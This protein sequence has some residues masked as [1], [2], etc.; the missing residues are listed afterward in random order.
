MKNFNY[1][2]VMHEKQKFTF[3]SYCKRCATGR[4]DQIMSPKQCHRENNGKSDDKRSAIVGPN[5]AEQHEKLM[6]FGRINLD[7]FALAE[8]QEAQAG[9]K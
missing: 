4:V 8:R 3:S 6:E 9:K 5:C 7:R 1:T 2:I